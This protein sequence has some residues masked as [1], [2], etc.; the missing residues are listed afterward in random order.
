MVIDK[1]QKDLKQQI[2][3]LNQENKKSLNEEK[4][5]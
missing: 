5:Q 2:A 4:L 3:E 1:L